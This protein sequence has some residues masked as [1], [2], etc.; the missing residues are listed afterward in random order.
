[1]LSL[2]VP[3]V[4]HAT[5]QTSFGSGDIAEEPDTGHDLHKSRSSNAG[6]EFENAQEFP[7][8]FSDV[9]SYAT[10]EGSDVEMEVE[11]KFHDER[12]LDEE[13]EVESLY[14][15]CSDQESVRYIDDSYTEDEL[16]VCF[17][18]ICKHNTK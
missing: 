1:M 5:T 13:A 4:T 6:G 12:V 18:F 11:T 2:R 9:E 16:D 8:D 10:A 14:E 15:L 3:I 7:D 17:S